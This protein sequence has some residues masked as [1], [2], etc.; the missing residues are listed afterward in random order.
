MKI[1]GSQVGSVA[2]TYL[3]KVKKVAP[4]EGTDATLSTDTVELSADVS[5]IETARKIIAATPDVREEKVE[6]LRQQIQNGTYRPPAEEIAD[7]ILAE[8]QLSKLTR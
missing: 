4:R 7:K 1:T 2:P 8:S 6:A 5:T 3:D